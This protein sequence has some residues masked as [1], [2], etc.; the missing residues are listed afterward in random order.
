MTQLRDYSGALKALKMEEWVALAEFHAVDPGLLIHR[1][2]ESIKK[3]E[4]KMK[5]A[6]IDE[7]FRDTPIKDLPPAAPKITNTPELAAHIFDREEWAVA[8]APELGFWPLGREI[9]PLR[10]KLTQKELRAKRRSIDFLFRNAQDDRLIVAEAKIEDDSPT[11]SALIQALMYAVEMATPAQLDRVRKYLDAPSIVV[12][13]PCVDIYLIAVK[14]NRGNEQAAKRN[15]VTNRERIDVASKKIV[16]QLVASPEVS[17]RVRRIAYIN[18]VV[19]AGEL[20]LSCEYS[21]T[22]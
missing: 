20:M 14:P 16:E 19:S 7:P 12:D 8:G 18:G 15:T 10:S 1:V 5:A 3:M 13:P 17:K 9:S 21:Y 22:A 4:A 11:Y 2:R 6:A